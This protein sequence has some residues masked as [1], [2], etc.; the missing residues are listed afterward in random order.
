M[1]LPK[2]K[3]EIS[4]KAPVGFV[5]ARS[6]CIPESENKKDERTLLLRFPILSIDILQFLSAHAV[7]LPS[8]FICFPFLTFAA[9]IFY[10]PRLHFCVKLL[11]AIE[12]WGRTLST[13]QGVIKSRK[14][15]KWRSRRKEE[16][17][18]QTLVWVLNGHFSNCWANCLPDHDCSCT[19]CF[20]VEMD[21]FDKKA[22]YK[23]GIK[24]LDSCSNKT[25]DLF[26]QIYTISFFFKKSRNS[27]MEMKWMEFS[28]YVL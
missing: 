5:V 19:V 8:L 28:A 20:Q 27:H 22:H 2:K 1:V 15:H 25:T 23:K 10:G 11:S 12:N 7:C 17:E 16:E 4:H 18:E 24:Y 9:S 3:T 26:F 6:C 14:P 21:Y 13:R